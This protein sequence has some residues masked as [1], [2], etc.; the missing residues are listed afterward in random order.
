KDTDRDR[1]A[2][3]PQP[4][5]M[6]KRKG[7]NVAG[8]QKISVRSQ[9]WTCA[10]ILSPSTQ[11]RTMYRAVL[12]SAPPTIWPMSAPDNLA[13]ETCA[14]IERSPSGPSTTHVQRPHRP[15]SWPTAKPRFSLLNDRVS[16]CTGRV[17]AHGIQV[18]PQAECTLSSWG[19]RQE[20]NGASPQS[21]TWV[22]YQHL[23]QCGGSRR[24]WCAGA[25]GLELLDALTQ[26]LQGGDASLDT[27]D[28][29]RQLCIQ[30]D[31]P[32]LAGTLKIA[33]D[34]RLDLSE[35]QSQRSQT[36]DHLHTPDCFFAKE[37]VVALTAAQG[38]EEPEVLVV[39]QDFDRHAGAA[40]ELPDGHHI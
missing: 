17:Q 10:N 25:C 8:S 20:A 2:P 24:S 6:R 23:R 38:V 28:G 7:M 19:E 39:A 9:G 11:K 14:T 3:N 16:T 22:S 21:T 5:G 12:R 35:G 27:R 4:Q 30:Q 1:R 37:A 34:E 32:Q 26:R 15:T 18:L 31:A 29:L 40:G 33:H 36:L 13:C